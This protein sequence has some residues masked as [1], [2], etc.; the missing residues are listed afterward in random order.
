MLERAILM[1]PDSVARRA[2][3]YA[4]DAQQRWMLT[5][6]RAIR[7][8]FARAA[9]GRGDAAEQAWMLRQP[10]AVRESYITEVLEAPGPA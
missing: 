5:Q 10:K 3:R 1:A 6:P 7:A 9:L 4:E 2:A 8:S